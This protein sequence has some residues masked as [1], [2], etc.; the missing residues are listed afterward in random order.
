MRRKKRNTLLSFISLFFFTIFRPVLNK[1]KN[2]PNKSLSQVNLKDLSTLTS[3]NIRLD[4]KKEIN[5]KRPK[6]Q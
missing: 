1:K 5:E 2:K 4:K 6:I 3:G